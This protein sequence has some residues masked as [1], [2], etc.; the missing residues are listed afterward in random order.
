MSGYQERVD[1]M[2][3]EV[4]TLADVWPEEARAAIVGLNPA[5]ISVELG[6]YYQGNVGQRQLRKLAEAG[7][8]AAP[9]GRQFEEVARASGVGLTDIVKRPTRGEGDVGADELA[10]GAKLLTDKLEQRAVPL[11]ICVFRHPVQVLLGS[12]GRPGLQSQRTAWGA[13]VF[14]MPGPFEKRDVAA[15]VLS[16]LTELLRD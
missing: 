9:R 7:V 3:Q 2:G 13:Q 15:Q 1:W 5:P 4:L 10:H 16:D 11:V 8:L 12:E 14:R 6:H